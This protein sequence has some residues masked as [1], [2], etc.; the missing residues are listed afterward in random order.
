[1]AGSAIATDQLRVF[2]EDR[3]LLAGNLEAPAT[4]FRL[5]KILVNYDHIVTGRCGDADDTTPEANSLNAPKALSRPVSR[6]DG[7]LLSQLLRRVN[8]S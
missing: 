4:R 8:H 2:F 6:C 5:T 1:M 3:H 7:A